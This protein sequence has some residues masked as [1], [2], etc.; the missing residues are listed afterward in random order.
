MESIEVR[1]NEINME[2]LKNK[3]ERVTSQKQ[4][5]KNVRIDEEKKAACTYVTR[6]DDV[7]EGEGEKEHEKN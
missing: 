3:G 5:D 2:R 4:D 1:L 7:E 6:Q